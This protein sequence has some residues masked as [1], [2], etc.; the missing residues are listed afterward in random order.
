[1]AKLQDTRIFIGTIPPMVG[2]DAFRAPAIDLLNEEILRLAS[3]E[4]I[5]LIDY[6]RALEGHPEAFKDDL[7][8]NAKGYALMQ[9]ALRQ[10][11]AL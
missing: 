3:R 2:G 1:M 10:A 5:G 9:K 8:V 6:H 11:G 7:H 4:A